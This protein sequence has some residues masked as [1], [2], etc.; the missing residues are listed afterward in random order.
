ML[1]VN[2]RPEYTEGYEGFYLL[3][4]IKGSVSNTE[5]RYIIRDHDMEKFEAKKNLLIEIVEFLNK[6][7]GDLIN[8]EIKDS[9]YNMKK[10][11]E[12]HME[13]IE[14]AKKSMEEIG[15]EPLISPI[16]GGTDGAS[17]SYKGL[18]C[19]NI[20][21]GGYNYHGR[22]ELLPVESLRKG[23]E[24]LLQIIKNLEHFDFEK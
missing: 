4:G 15:V 9:Y 19:P 6:K 12:P 20:F 14:L 21:T 23:K 24:L 8:L 11:I 22:Y 10:M 13:I 16:R 7:Y 18:P 17:L 1:P 2:M 3:E 5:M